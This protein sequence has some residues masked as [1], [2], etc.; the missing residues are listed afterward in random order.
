MKSENSRSHWE[1]GLWPNIWDVVIVGCGIVGL[2]AAI[3]LKKKAPTKHILVIDKGERS[4]GAST[5]NAGFSCFGSPSE[6]LDD[7]ERMDESE[8]IDLVRRR[9]K[10]MKYIKTAF[11]AEDLDLRWKGSHEVFFGGDEELYEKCMAALPRLNDLVSEAVKGTCDFRPQPRVNGVQ[12]YIGAIFQPEEGALN[13][14]KLWWALYKAAVTHN[15]RFYFDKM[16][17]ELSA[18]NGLITLKLESGSALLC[19]QV[20]IATNAFTDSILDT[21]DL[22]IRMAKNQVYVTS[23]L[24]GPSLDGTFHSRKGYIYWRSVGRR[25]LI[26]GA[27]HLDLG[28]NTNEENPKVREYLLRFVRNH[29]VN[30]EDICI[31]KKWVGRLGIGQSKTPLIEEVKP[32]IFVAIRLGGMGVA[33]GH[34]VGQRVANLVIKNERFEA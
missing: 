30:A 33:I 1:E 27:R 3:E 7:L 5:K 14:A 8:V 17:T 34:E 25:I 6:I 19:R 24:R 32:G 31:E 28:E 18:E 21:S 12:S 16:V 22:D 15:A 20:I 9:W 11:A 10:G 26:G 13:P 29:L 4:F 2:N 23:E